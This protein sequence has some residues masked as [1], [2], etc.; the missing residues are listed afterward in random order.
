[1]RWPNGNPTH[2]ACRNGAGATPID[3]TEEELPTCINFCFPTVTQEEADGAACVVDPCDAQRIDEGGV[4]LCPDEFACVP[5]APSS[6]TGTCIQRTVLTACEK[7]GSPPCPTGTFC[8]LFTSVFARPGFIDPSAEGMCMPWIREG[9]LCLEAGDPRAIECEP[10]TYCRPTAAGSWRCA[11]PCESV[12]DCACASDGYEPQCIGEG[13]SAPT[14]STCARL[15]QE[16]DF[17]EDAPPCCGAATCDDAADTVPGNERG[18]CCLPE[19]AECETDADC[20]GTNLCFDS[21]CTPCGGVGEMPTEAGCCG[22]L[23]PDGDNLCSRECVWQGTPANDGDDCT[24]RTADPSCQGKILCTPAGAECNPISVSPDNNCDGIDDDCDG[25]PDDDDL[26]TCTEPRP[27]GCQPGFVASTPGREVCA[28]PDNVECHYGTGTHRQT[29]CSRIA[30]LFLGPG[31]CLV[32][33]TVPAGGC[34]GPSDCSPGEL[35]G[36]AGSTCGPAIEG[37]CEK[38]SSAMGWH[39]VPCCRLDRTGSNLCWNPEDRG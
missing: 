20:C 5:D 38:Y 2:Q 27:A 23:T 16:C 31:D 11:R 4:I 14:C 37:C 9:A 21:K 6:R 18:L 33:H 36:P 3:C 13:S 12:D 28:S 25:V 29:H 32:G 30:G 8:R 7:D 22:S 10:G 17:G 1:M 26:G 39:H 19:E 24:P 15:G 35:C 34:T